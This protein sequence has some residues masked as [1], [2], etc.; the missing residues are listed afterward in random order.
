[1][2]D[3]AQGPK[4]S[5][6]RPDFITFLVPQNVRLYDRREAG[7]GAVAAR[8]VGDPS[9]DLSRGIGPASEFSPADDASYGIEAPTSP[10]S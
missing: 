1:M 4:A 9:A 10:S 2:E 7:T 8:P 3:M 6:I 5:P